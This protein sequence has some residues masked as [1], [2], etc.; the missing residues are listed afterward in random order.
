MIIVW[1]ALLGAS[2]V[3]ALLLA[4]LYITA[5]AKRP[6]TAIAAR[7]GLRLWVV[8][9][10]V[11]LA[12][13]YV[14]LP[15]MTGPYWGGQWLLWP[16]L[17][18][19]FVAVGGGSLARI[20]RS[21]DTLTEQINS[22][23]PLRFGGYGWR[24]RTPRDVKQRASRRKTPATSG[25][26]GLAAI[27]VALCVGVLVNGGIS[28]ATTWLPGG[29]TALAN[30]A[31]ITPEAPSASLPA[32]DV[33]HL[34]VVS[35]EVA[36]Y[37]GQQALT[38][39]PRDISSLYHT[40]LTEYTLQ[41]VNDHLYWIAPLVY[42]N[43][44][45]NAGSWESPGYVAVDAEN[46]DTVGLVRTQ[47]HLR[48]L[49]DS[50]L[51]RGLLRHVYLSGYTTSD[52]VDPT[53]Q[54][55][56][57]W[58][59]YYTVDAMRPTRGFTGETVDKVLLVD[60]Q[61][62]GVTGYSPAK[63][64]AWV[65]RTMPATSVQQYVS[66]WGQYSRQVGF[67]A[68]GS[69]QQVPTFG[70]NEGPALVYNTISQPAW[71]LP[72]ASAGSSGTTTGVTLFD[73]RSMTG[74]YY[75]IPGLGLGDD[76][77]TLIEG[78]VVNTRGYSANAVQLCEIDGEP[79]WVA[80]MT[81]TN[82]TGVTFQGVALVDALQQRSANVIMQPTKDQALAA[83][84]QWLAVSSPQPQNPGPT[85]AT[86]TVKG[87]VARISSASQ[88][89]ATV[90]FI[91]LDGQTRIFKASLT[92]SAELPLVQPGDTV[93][94]AYEETGQSTV[95]VTSFTDLSVQVTTPTPVPSPTATATKSARPSPTATPKG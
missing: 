48:Y 38:N 8:N 70:K 17:I 34:V 7:W 30:L 51:N 54:V 3:T 57:N 12:L 22:D 66:W 32:T 65:D 23:A 56:D 21:L 90:Y 9:V 82:A 33:H 10:V 2:V 72:M 43:V 76:V 78:S 11:C 26:A 80:T 86:V 13:L 93:Q 44:W 87:L 19:G 52:L 74:R 24:K 45:A 89:G 47:Y 91:L 67:D 94:L 46:P 31:A 5:G 25:R 69:N 64:P 16:L 88:N 63:T 14:A 71:M 20:W 81:Q 58:N 85:T 75:P 77:K 84:A 55:D 28:L 49:M 37:I 41:S 92:I 18:S 61:T 60:P 27:A 39:G 83:Y 50:V 6:A 59:P 79:T 62:G 68:N 35:R 1:Y 40:E 95:T 42:D 15:A 73:A 29:H 53:F 4:L 36:L